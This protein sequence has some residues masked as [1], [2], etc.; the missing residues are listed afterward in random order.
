MLS[1]RKDLLGIK[2]LSKEDIYLI[3]DTAVEMKE[4]SYRRTKRLITYR[5]RAL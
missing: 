2:E 3:L 1:G 4:R 5:A